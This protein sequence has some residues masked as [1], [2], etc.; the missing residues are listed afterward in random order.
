[1][2]LKSA[3]APTSSWLALLIVCVFFLNARAGSAAS[4]ALDQW[5]AD[6]LGRRE[7]R[8][9]ERRLSFSEALGI[10]KEFVKRLRPELGRPVGYKV[11]LV[12]RE[13]QLKY[14]V[15]APLRGV[16][17]EKMLLAN[18][19]DVPRDFGVRPLLEADLVVVVKDKGINKAT[20]L[21]DVVEHIKDVIAFIELPDAFIR[22]NP[23]PDGALL[24]AGNVGARLGVLGQRIPVNGTAEFAKALA[25]M[26]VV[27]IDDGG[28]E[29][30][31]GQG[32]VILDH[33]LNA[34]LW[35]VEELHRSGERLKA[36]DM[37]S[38]GSIK[39]IP[40]PASKAVTVRYDGL[41][42][43]PISASVRFH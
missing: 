43:G 38:L 17:L 4:T 34:V 10:Q 28:N 7:A 9:F 13:A 22:T 32:K 29:L 18:N 27:I 26:H 5:T 12:T 42:G 39:A 8:G 14:G 41:P 2:N 11:G 30:G 20:S 15:Q 33:P 19:A 40:L 21:L 37:I 3:L 1:M 36:G 23:P 35:L 6:Y 24:T 16:L 25:E 31:R